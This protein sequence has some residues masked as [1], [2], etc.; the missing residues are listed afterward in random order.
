[1][2]SGRVERSFETKISIEDSDKVCFNIHVLRKG[3]G[4]HVE[5]FMKRFGKLWE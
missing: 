5:M 3:E 1:M 4:E 2:T